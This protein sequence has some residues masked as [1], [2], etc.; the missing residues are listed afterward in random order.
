MPRTAMAGFFISIF[1][2]VLVLVLDPWVL[3]SRLAARC[4]HHWHTGSVPS[5]VEGRHPCLPANSG[6][7]SR[8]PFRRSG[9]TKMRLL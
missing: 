4:R 6:F 3:S 8:V 5:T 1:I 2:L 7:Q 9:N